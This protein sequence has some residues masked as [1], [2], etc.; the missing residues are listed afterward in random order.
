MDG[1]SDESDGLHAEFVLTPDCPIAGVTES[2]DVVTFTPGKGERV[3]PQFVLAAE[4]APPDPLI[5]PIVGT[6]GTVVCRVC[7]DG[8]P[9]ACDQERCLSWDPTRLPLS[10]FDVRFRDGTLRLSVAATDGDELRAT[11]AALNDYGFD[12]SLDRIVGAV[13]AVSSRLRIVD[14]SSVTDR[15]RELAAAAADRGYF[16]P[17]GPSAAALAEEFDIAPGTLSEHLRR[18]QAELFRQTFG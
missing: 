18:V 11:M 14:L 7:G 3:N 6:D 8:S 16:S 17:D 5:E 10:P 15:Q 13:E 1:A 12:A 4:E 9:T 2:H